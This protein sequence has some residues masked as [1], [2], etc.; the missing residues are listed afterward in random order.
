[1]GEAARPVGFRDRLV[2]DALATSDSFNAIR[3][4]DGERLQPL[5]DRITARRVDL[6]FETPPMVLELIRGADTRPRS[7]DEDAASGSSGSR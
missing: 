6:E 4:L 7:F 5:L 2:T 3:P 1:M